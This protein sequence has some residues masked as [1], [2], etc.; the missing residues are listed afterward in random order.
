M[1]WQIVHGLKCNRSA[2]SAIAQI[3][4]KEYTAKVAEYS[5]ELLLVGI[6]YDR[7][8]KTHSCRIERCQKP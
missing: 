3:R 6:N 1:A 5:G 4:K 8:K 2:R 7:K